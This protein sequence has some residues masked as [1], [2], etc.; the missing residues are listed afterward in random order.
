MTRQKAPDPLPRVQR[1]MDDIEKGWGGVKEADST[2]NTRS[3]FLDS[4]S[5]SFFVVVVVVSLQGL[6]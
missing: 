5:F 2:E 1:Q 3:L 4:E 6:K